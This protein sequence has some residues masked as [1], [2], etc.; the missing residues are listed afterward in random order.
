MIMCREGFVFTGG[1]TDWLLATIQC[2]YGAEQY[3]RCV[4]LCDK[5]SGV[6]EL[7]VY[8]GKAL[9]KIYWRR[10][11]LLQTLQHGQ[12]QFYKQHQACYEV[13]REA[14]KILGR[15]KD[16]GSFD[17]DA[18]SQKMLDR[19][20]RDYMLET[21]R[22]KEMK[23]CFLCLRRQQYQVTAENVP[24]TG[25][26]K[27]QVKQKASANA[28]IKHS[29]LIPHGIIKRLANI[30]KRQP[31]NPKCVVFGVSGTKLD[32]QRTPATSTIHMLCGSCEQM[33]NNNGE[34][35]FISFFENLIDPTLAKSQ[36]ELKYGKELYYFCLSLIFRTLCP[37]QNEYINTDEVYQLLVQCRAYLLEGRLDKADDLPQVFLII[38]PF[39]DDETD[40][41]KKS[42]IEQS[43]VSYTSKFGLDCKREELDSFESVYA[44]FF[45]VKMGVVIVVV[46]FKPSL[47]YKL[48]DNCRV[49]PDG[50]LYVVPP[51]HARAD[52]V[53]AGVQTALQLLFDV[54][55]SDL[56]KVNKDNKSG[57][58]ATGLADST[59]T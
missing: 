50:G 46:K 27:G 14:I 15:A 26:D 57:K 48:S 55:T 36:Q 45:L 39:A 43:S 42:F 22:L 44:S 28:S 12:R 23:R 16:S 11:Q 13:A 38:H 54:Y 6:A 18:D 34:D 59:A 21:N 7:Q 20:M 9:Y 51:A 58:A 10:Q 30:D 3:T 31:T 56:D 52:I 5:V 8:K 41:R 33:I 35:P 40:E 1:E 19:V 25:E 17:A 29:H 24:T 53:P 49:S 2:C 37:S 4:E 32:S 47:S